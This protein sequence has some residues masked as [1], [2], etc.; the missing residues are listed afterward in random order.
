MLAAQVTD[1]ARCRVLGIAGSLGAALIRIEVSQRLG[2]VAVLRDGCSMEVISCALLATL[3]G[4]MGMHGLTKRAT[5]L[6]EVAELDLK[7]DAIS[8]VGCHGEDGALGVA[9]ELGVLEEALLGECGLVGHSGRVVHDL[10]SILAD[11]LAGEGR[12]EESQGSV[13][14]HSERG[15]D[16]GSEMRTT[17]ACSVSDRLRATDRYCR[18]WQVGCRNKK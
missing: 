5:L 18:Y 17:Y 10:L 12:Q 7:L 14:S 4:P 13:D 8:A 6:G 15:C 3:L 1:F 9:L 11:D 16:G 2:A